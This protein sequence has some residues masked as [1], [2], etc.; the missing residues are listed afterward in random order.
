VEKEYIDIEIY[1]LT[2]SIENRITGDSFNIQ[3]VKLMYL[4]LGY[5]N[6]N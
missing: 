4:K 1:K 2:N 6:L 5:N 3:V